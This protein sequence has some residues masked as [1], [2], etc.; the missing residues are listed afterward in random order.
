MTPR[1]VKALEQVDND[2]VFVVAVV[3][4]QLVNQIYSI[5]VKHFLWT[6]FGAPF[7]ENFYNGDWMLGPNHFCWQAI[8]SIG[9]DINAYAFHIKPKN[10]D[11]AE[12]IVEKIMSNKESILQYK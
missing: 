6:V 8:C 4:V 7:D 1:E 3:L 2:V 9:Y 5:Q 10:F 11:E 12:K